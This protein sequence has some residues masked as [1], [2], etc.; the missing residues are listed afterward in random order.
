M[1]ILVT[2]DRGFV[3]NHLVERLRGDGYD[4]LGFDLPEWDITDPNQ[5]YDFLA[6]NR[7]DQIFHLAAQTCV[8]DSFLRPDR[9]LNVNVNG[10]LNLLQALR[11]LKFK[12]PL[13]MTGTSEEYGYD[14]LSTRYITEDSPCRPVTPYGVGKL[15]ATRLGLTYARRYG[16]RVIATRASNHIGPGQRG[17]VTAEWARQIA[18]IEQGRREVLLHGDLNVRRS[19][20]DVSDVVEA[21]VRAI[22]L[23][24]GVYNVSTTSS[25]TLGEILEFFVGMASCPII[26]RSDPSLARPTEVKNFAVMSSDPFMRFTN[27]YPERSIRST[28]EDVLNWWRKNLDVS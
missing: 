3:G 18:E 16:L 2:G 6:E 25:V 13:L 24:S 8:P 28:L 4:V 22:R 14:Q 21:Y 27:W 23:E 17:G 15:A 10:A 20:L 9:S 5:V 19:F 11:A 12:G 1:K 7:P 26:T